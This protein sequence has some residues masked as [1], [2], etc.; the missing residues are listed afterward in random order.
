MT[1]E[2]ERL[3]AKLKR[4]VE[5]MAPE[6]FMEQVEQAEA[7]SYNQLT[8]MQINAEL[9]KHLLGIT[10]LKNAF[11]VDEIVWVDENGK[12]HRSPISNY[13]RLFGV[14]RLWTPVE[15][16]VIG[17]VDGKCQAWIG[18]MPH[19][20]EFCHHHKNGYRAATTCAIKYFKSRL[21]DTTSTSG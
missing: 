10:H 18:G 21:L 7:D 20:P 5:E 16:N 15:V 4:C 11:S 1:S 9:E 8:D 14:S 6:E 19:R 12:H 3:V 2:H 17:P 13:C